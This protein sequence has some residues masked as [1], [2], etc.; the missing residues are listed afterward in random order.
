MVS[1]FFLHERKSNDEQFCLKKDILILVQTS[2]HPLA[3]YQYFIYLN[4]RNYINVI[5]ET[6]H[7]LQI[8]IAFN[9]KW[10]T[11]ITNIPSRRTGL[12]E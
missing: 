10:E 6:H 12:F 4:N 1:L 2:S 5:R 9:V 8:L 11:L 7:I 3:V